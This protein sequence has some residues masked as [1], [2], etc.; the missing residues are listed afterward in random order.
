MKRIRRII[1]ALDPKA[2]AT[3]GQRE[4]L[5]AFRIRRAAVLVLVLFL[6]IASMTSCSVHATTGPHDAEHADDG[7]SHAFDVGQEASQENSQN[8]SA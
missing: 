3:M 5:E 2:D 6:L 8:Q 1:R 7:T 4:R